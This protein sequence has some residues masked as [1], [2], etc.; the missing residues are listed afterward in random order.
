MLTAKA[1][2]KVLEV[3]FKLSFICEAN[4]SN[5][6]FLSTI[7]LS[8]MTYRGPIFHHLIGFCLRGV[9]LDTSFLRFLL[10]ASLVLSPIL[11]LFLDRRVLLCT[12]LFVTARAFLLHI[13]GI[14][15]ILMHRLFWHCCILYLL[16]K[17]LLVRSRLVSN[18][19]LAT[20]VTI[21]FDSIIIDLFLLLNLTVELFGDEIRISRIRVSIV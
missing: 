21:L 16:S 1:Q 20:I 4:I 5:S 15:P 8:P 9:P 18:N 12:R 13:F 6:I 3:P 10:L 19:G 17:R 11:T 7:T 14:N 2:L